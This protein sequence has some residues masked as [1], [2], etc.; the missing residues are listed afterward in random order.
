MLR[1]E[2][3]RVHA[4][5]VGV[6]GVRRGWRQLGRERTPVAGCT[7]ARLMRQMGLKGVLRGKETW[8]T[9]PDRGAPCPAGR[10]NRQFLAPRPNLLWVSDV[11]HVATWQGFV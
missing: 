2:V 9:V 7:V 8:T 11:T 3:R 6:C 5:N 10:V 1:A 4:E